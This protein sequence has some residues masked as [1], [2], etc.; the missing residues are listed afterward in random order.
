MK[1]NIEYQTWVKM[2]KFMV[3]G[4]KVFNNMCDWLGWCRMG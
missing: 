3:Q 2:F 4:K 1:K